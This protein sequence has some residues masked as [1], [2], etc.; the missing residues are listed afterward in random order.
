MKC[1]AIIPFGAGESC[2]HEYTVTKANTVAS[3]TFPKPWTHH[4]CPKCK[5]TT[6]VYA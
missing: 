2:G 3:G 1:A 4:R 6:Q 5:G